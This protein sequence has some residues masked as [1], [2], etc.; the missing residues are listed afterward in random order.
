MRGQLQASPAPCVSSSVCGLMPYGGGDSRFVRLLSVRF[1]AVQQVVGS[2]KQLC[3][4]GPA[5]CWGHQ[6][7]LWGHGA[8]CSSLQVLFTNGISLLSTRQKL[9]STARG[10]ADHHRYPHGSPWQLSQAP[11]AAASKPPSPASSFCLCAFGCGFFPQPRATATRPHCPMSSG[12]LGISG[13]QKAS[14]LF[15]WLYGF[16]KLSVI[17]RHG[18]WE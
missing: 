9:L 18:G 13:Q 8:P 12:P 14:F 11:S 2:P 1:P 3:A 7:P 5:G 17:S 6:W 10:G 15:S 16:L 4:E